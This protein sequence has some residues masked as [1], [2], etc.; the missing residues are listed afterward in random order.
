MF[1]RKSVLVV[2]LAVGGLSCLPGRASADWLFRSYVGWRLALR[3][4]YGADGPLPGGQ[5]VGAT[6]FAGDNPQAGTPNAAQWQRI[7]TRQQP[8]VYSAAQ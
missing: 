2:L 5:I 7:V 6:T 1:G 4:Q 3:A 8:Q